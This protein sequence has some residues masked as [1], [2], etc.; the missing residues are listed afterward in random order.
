MRERIDGK[1]VTGNTGEAIW[2]G[3]ECRWT[4][5]AEFRAWALANGYSKARCSL[6]RINPDFGY[7]PSNCRWVT[8]SQ[9]SR[10][11]YDHALRQETEQTRVAEPWDVPF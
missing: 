2:R 6:D 1:R 5:W 11:A 7:A 10:Y 3:L 4:S 9:N 8:V